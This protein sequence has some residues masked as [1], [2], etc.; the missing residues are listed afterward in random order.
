MPDIMVVLKLINSLTKGNTMIDYAMFSEKGNHKVHNIV[1]EAKQY[2]HS[3]SLVFDRLCELGKDKEF[4]E[5]TDTMV[6][7]IVFD[8]IGY[9]SDVGFYNVEAIPGHSGIR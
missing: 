8:A 6:R 3:W 4:S 5:C 1:I 7:E 9:G 2:N